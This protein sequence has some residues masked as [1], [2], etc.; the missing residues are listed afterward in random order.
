MTADKHHRYNTSEKGRARQRRWQES[1]KGK[2][3]RERHEATR[4]Y[5]RKRTTRLEAEREQVVDQLA[6]VQKEI[7]CLEAQTRTP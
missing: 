7:A 1:P 5:L 4:G 6:E 3:A 2:A